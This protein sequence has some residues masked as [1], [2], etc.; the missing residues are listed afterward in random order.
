MNTDPGP[1]K[2][3]AAP[4]IL[5]PGGDG[6]VKR[7]SPSFYAELDEDFDHFKGHT[8][9]QVFAFSE[10][11]PSWEIHPH[12][13]E[14]VYLLEGD[15]EFVLRTAAGD[16]TVRVSEP[17]TYVVVPK[18]TWHTAR[19]HAPTKMLFVTPGEGTLNEAQPPATEV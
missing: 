9:V 8:L 19:P 11:W 2:L 3:A 12:G 15:T 5:T 1:H 13:D 7:M 6:V 17:G 14:L 18:N 4:Y 10:A 16:Q